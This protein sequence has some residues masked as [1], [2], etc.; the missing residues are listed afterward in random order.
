VSVQTRRQVLEQA[1]ILPLAAGL[2]AKPIKIAGLEIIAESSCL[3]NES[4][5]GFRSLRASESSKIILLCGVS[6]VDA[7]WAFRLRERAAAG[8]WLIWEISPFAC[9]PRNFNKQARIMSEVFGVAIREPIVLSSDR[10]ASTGM[11][12]RYRW[13]CAALT[14]SFSAVIPVA[15]SER[16]TIALYGNTPVVMRRAIG[17]G[18]L[19]LLGSMLGPNLRAN[20]YEAR[21]IG[22]GILRAL[23]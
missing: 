3:S 20:E 12:V 7:S 22:T 19:V 14:R 11:Y 2:K 1:L 9:E 4:A 6:A 16:E 18:G 5:D 17:H 15:C 21:A 8:T 13:P 10:L 23:G